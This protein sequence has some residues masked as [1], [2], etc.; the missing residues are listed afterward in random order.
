MHLIP[1]R[2]LTPFVVSSSGF[3][4]RR[5]DAQRHPPPLAVPLGIGPLPGLEE[6]LNASAVQG[7]PASGLEETTPIDVKSFV[8]ELHP[9]PDHDYDNDNDNRSAGASLTT[10]AAGANARHQRREARASPPA[11]GG[12]PGRGG[13]DGSQVRQ[14][15]PP[16]PA[17]LTPI[18]GRAWDRGQP[19]L[20][21]VREVG[22]RPPSPAT[23][24]GRK[25]PFRRRRLPAQPSSG[26]GVFR[27]AVPG[28]IPRF[29]AHSA[30]HLPPAAL[31][32]PEFRHSPS[33]KLRRTPRQPSSLCEP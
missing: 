20:R 24:A 30:L 16:I 22:A 28:P 3:C 8:T 17:I 29:P 15:T 1:G 31:P 14:P 23:A 25:L 21:S 27:N 5:D 9:L 2:F 26:A 4:R 11:R 10:S 12:W 33:L 19:A 6:I 18:I 7:R 13:G 32:Q